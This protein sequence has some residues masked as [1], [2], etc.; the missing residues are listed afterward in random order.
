MYVCI[1]CFQRDY[2]EF[3]F[4]F[5][6]SAADVYNVMVFS[7]KRCWRLNV[8]VAAVVTLSKVRTASRR[9]PTTRT[10][11]RWTW[12][13]VTRIRP[14][15]VITITNL[16]NLVSDQDREKKS[17]RRRASNVTLAL[18]LNDTVSLVPTGSWF[19]GLADGSLLLEDA[20]RR[21]LA[22]HP[23]LHHAAF[24]Q[25]H[26]QTHQ[27]VDSEQES[28]CS[29]SG[30]DRTNSPYDKESAGPS[31]KS[32]HRPFGLSLILCRNVIRRAHTDGA[33]GFPYPK[34]QDFDVNLGASFR[35][36][37]N[38]NEFPRANIT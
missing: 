23:A 3:F 9:G 28:S 1:Y 5:C 7:G 37:H 38:G 8:T 12:S 13:A 25:H 31:G 15:P 32:N 35:V 33:E 34:L 6:Q 29:E 20:M 16:T 14:F 26:H 21:R 22:G 18:V 10:T 36:A 30:R 11:G 17:P 27:D 19:S 2:F 4:F 24:L